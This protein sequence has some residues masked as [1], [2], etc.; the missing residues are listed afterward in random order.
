[1]STGNTGIVT[2]K[3]SRYAD[4]IHC[5]VA[6]STPSSNIM[7]GIATFVEVS[8]TIQSHRRRDYPKRLLIQPFSHR[9]H[10]R[11]SSRSTHYYLSRQSVAFLEATSNKLEGARLCLFGRILLKNLAIPSAVIIVNFC[12][13]EDQASFI[14]EFAGSPA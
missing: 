4:V 10:E 5:I 2:D 13:G 12:L 1:M 11:R 8:N 6:V 14:I 3:T 7:T 9:V